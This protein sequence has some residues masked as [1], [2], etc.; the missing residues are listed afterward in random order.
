MNSLVLGL[1]AAVCWALHDTTIRYLS[2]TTPMMVALLTVL[3]FGLMFQ[4]VVI[5][6]TGTPVRMD[7]TSLTLSIGTGAA[8]L[9]ASVCLY[10]AF[11]RGPVRLVSPIIAAYPILSIAFAVADGS[12]VTFGQGAA[13]LAIVA[14]VGIVAAQ[15]D[16]ADIPPIGPTIAL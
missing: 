9:V 4:T 2:R 10:F 13:V 7:S 12:P 5:V 15:I 8:F 1:V 16:N 11:Q 6:A 3:F 14:G